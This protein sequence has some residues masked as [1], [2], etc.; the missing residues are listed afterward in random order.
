MKI[1]KAKD[2]CFELHSTVDCSGGNYTIIRPDYPM[3]NNLFY[4]GMHLAAEV[5]PYQVRAISLC[6]K[7]CKE[8]NITRSEKRETNPNDTHIGV[9]NELDVTIISEFHNADAGK[10]ALTCVMNNRG[11]LT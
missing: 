8:M 7:F 4:D 9:R 3:L 11:D 5:A 6:G 10:F 1:L 2:A